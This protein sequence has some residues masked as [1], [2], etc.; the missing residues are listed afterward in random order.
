MSLNIH[1][2]FGVPLEQQLIF[3]CCFIFILFLKV[4]IKE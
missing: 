1:Q 2:V 3:F 4:L